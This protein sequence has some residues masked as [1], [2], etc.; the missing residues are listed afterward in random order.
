MNEWL[1]PLLAALEAA[2]VMLAAGTSFFVVLAWRV[3]TDAEV[4]RY[5]GIRGS[6]IVAGSLAA[7]VVAQLLQAWYQGHGLA[8]LS[9]D[10]GNIPEV[11]W[12][13]IET[14][15]PGKVWL[16][17]TF[18]AVLTIVVVVA[19]SRGR[20]TGSNR[21]VGGLFILGCT[22]V[23]VASSALSGHY[24][25]E[26][27]SPLTVPLHAVHLLATACWVGGLPMWILVVA[28]FMNED[29]G[30]EKIFVLVRGFSRA[31]LLLVLVAVASG[32]VLADRF[33]DN[34]GDL[35]G[36]WW[37]AFLVGKVLLILG[38]LYFA[39]GLR[40]ALS[41]GATSHFFGVR[42]S[43]VLRATW[44]LVLLL[45]A[46]A[47]AA[48]MSTVTPAIH[49]QPRWIFP[50]R[51]SLNAIGAN[52]NLVDVFWAGI[53]VFVSASL[54]ACVRIAVLGERVVASAWLVVAGLGAGISA[55]AAAVPASEETYRRSGVP[56]LAESV[57]SGINY[58]S[59][60]CVACHGTGA[61]GDGPLSSYTK[62]PPA[63]LSAPH[64][65]LHTAGDLFQWIGEGTPSGAMPGFSHVLDEEARWDL[66]NFLRAFSQ[67]FQARILGEHIAFNKPWLA[68]PDFYLTGLDGGASQLKALRGAPVL[69]A[70]ADSCDVARNS[71]GALASG[72]TNS[73]SVVL[74]C[75]RMQRPL[76][77]KGFWF[78]QSPEAVVSTY[79]LLSRTIED[80]G[81][82]DQLGVQNEMSIFVIDKFGYAR[83]RYLGPTIDDSQREAFRLA[84]KALAVESIVPDSPDDH[85]H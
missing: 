81:R 22:S 47:L 28:R 8:Q 72:T 4:F 6:R 36:T 25:G 35:F 1:A 59:E 2:A 32:F 64:T 63:D 14:T 60:N 42:P 39:N 13:Y 66:V 16:Y 5:I 61:R 20:E 41:A 73:L 53:L 68:A 31:A 71:A 10:A 55:W 79:A 48:S 65:A 3:G 26:S 52:K 82:N 51:V 70:I 84:I 45:F 33:V 7:F 18:A 77:G 80:K 67:G 54:V 40:T 30:R 38:A 74:A 75:R 19:C 29:K 43:P 83:A 27:A 58:F 62:L 34:Q 12:K 9:G 50:F 37:G 23:L 56:Y 85:V 57:A 24:V 69:L 11:W 21:G 49:A 44:E 15:D 76:S 17:R 78:A 46:L